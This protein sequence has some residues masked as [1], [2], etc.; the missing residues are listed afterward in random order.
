LGADEWA[1]GSA[2]VHVHGLHGVAIAPDDVDLAPG[3]RDVNS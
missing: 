1:K 3:T 2:V